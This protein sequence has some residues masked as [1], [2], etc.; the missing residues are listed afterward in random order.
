MSANYKT[1]IYWKEHREEVRSHARQEFCQ[2]QDAKMTKTA[3]SRAA[4]DDSSRAISHSGTSVSSEAMEAAARL[5][6]VRTT[7][8]AYHVQPL[9]AVVAEE[10]QAAAA[11]A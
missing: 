5:E 11:A 10:E 9:A 3:S 6:S 1:F 7:P 8:G 2:K 4:E